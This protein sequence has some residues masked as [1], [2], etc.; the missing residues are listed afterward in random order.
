M[1]VPGWEGHAPCLFLDAEWTAVG[2][3]PGQYGGRMIQHFP[4]GAFTEAK[5]WLA[6]SSFKAP[7]SLL[8]LWKN[9][10]MMLIFTAFELLYSFY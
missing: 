3:R 9:T 10:V 5:S 1:Y 8:I 6:Y 2:N 4:L 7:H